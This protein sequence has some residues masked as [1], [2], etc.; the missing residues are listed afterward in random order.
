M[1][2]KLTGRGL[3]ADRYILYGTACSAGRAGSQEGYFMLYRMKQFFNGIFA[4]GAEGE[5]VELLREALP[6]E[7]M[8]LFFQMNKAD[9][10]HALNVLKTAQSL[11]QDAGTG[12]QNVIQAEEARKLLVRCCLLHDVGRGYEM[13]PV[14]KSLAVLLDSL[15][16]N[17]A[18]EYGRNAAAGYLGKILQRYYQHAAIGSEML[19]KQGLT[20]E[21][22]IVELHHQEGFGGLDEQQKMI[23]LVLKQADNR[24]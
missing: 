18:R 4:Q 16:P 9:Q 8:R 12:Q 17:W 5:E 15:F 1:L 24:N 14:R 10:R 20:E 13:G 11:L 3:E 2:E 21:A 22:K 19:R 7:G 23:L 6:E